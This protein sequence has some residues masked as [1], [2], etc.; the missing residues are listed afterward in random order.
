MPTASFPLYSA[1]VRDSSVPSLICG[2]FAEPNELSAPVGDD[3][4]AEFLRVLEPALQSDRA[5][6]QRARDPADR[7]G[8]VL[9]L[10]ACTT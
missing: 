7:R 2:H 1:S 3:E 9:H 5:L 4:V 6:V 8:E 10:H